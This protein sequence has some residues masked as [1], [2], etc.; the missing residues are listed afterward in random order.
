MIYI[1]DLNL[2]A[3]Y[4]HGRDTL[5]TYE[6]E[7]DVRSP[8]EKGKFSYDAWFVEGNYVFYPW[9]QGALR[10]EWLRPARQG[11]P[12]FKRITPN[13]TALIRANVKA[14]IQYERDLG[15]SDDYV[16]LAN[17]RFAF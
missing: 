11:A 7:N 3:G 1:Q 15:E 12:D 13:L 2:V 5:A 4:V 6:V 9:L 10:Y 17:L 8:H 14:L 16:L